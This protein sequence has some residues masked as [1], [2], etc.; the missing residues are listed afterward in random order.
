MKRNQLKFILGGMFVALTMLTACGNDHEYTVKENQA[1]IAQTNT[2]GNA[3]QKLTVDDEPVSVSLNVRLSDPSAEACSFEIVADEEVLNEYNKLNVTE[4]KMLPAAQYSFST[5]V[6]TVEKEQSLS[7]PVDV[8]ILPMTDELKST[9]LKY[10]IGIRLVSKDGKKEVLASGSKYVILLDQVPK[11]A[12][13]L[14]NRNLASIL[15]IPEIT[16]TEYTVEMCVNMDILGTRVGQYNNQAL[17]YAGGNGEIYLRFGDAPI[18]GNRFQVKTM[19]T[20]M[21]SNML[22]NANTWYHIAVV[23]TGSNL[24]F[25]FNGVLDNS[26]DLPNNPMTLGPDFSI[27]SSGSYFVAQKAKMCQLRFWSKARSQM[28]IANNMYNV[29]PNSAG[30]EGYWKMDEGEGN[31]FKDS[32]PHGRHAYLSNSGYDVTWEQ[33]VRIDGK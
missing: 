31:E 26:L 6:I 24:Y 18:E 13:P 4:Y 11:Q 8:N 17:F 16:L 33:D 2:N 25:Y 27:I 30:L 3:S 10:A 23:C 9:G 14:F 20:Q 32:S 12:V 29:D 7:I 28:E 22:F 21:N 15:P 1:Y 5:N 19:G